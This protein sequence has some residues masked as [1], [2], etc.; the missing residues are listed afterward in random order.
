MGFLSRDRGLLSS[1]L[2]LS[3]SFISSSLSVFTFPGVK[4][5]KSV[6]MSA[7][8]SALL[9]RNSCSPLYLY[10]LS[11]EVVLSLSLSLMLVWFECVGRGVFAHLDI[12]DVCCA[13]SFRPLNSGALGV[14]FAVR[15]VSINLKLVDVDADTDAV[16]VAVA[17]ADA[18]A[19]SCI[20]M[21]FSAL[22]FAFLP[23]LLCGGVVAEVCFAGSFLSMN[24]GA[25]MVYF[26][27]DVD[28]VADATV[29]E[30]DANVDANADTG[31]EI[32]VTGSFLSM[33]CVVPMV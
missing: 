12:A 8:S 4:S 30:I 2:V 29:V 16:A 14:C 3:V 1:A 22:S 18:D 9:V 5:V 17:E 24:D 26:N 13:G 33:S 19:A 23:V 7:S 21:S 20:S 15:F 32:R 6:T 28:V 11:C 10:L 25:L 27:V 31:S